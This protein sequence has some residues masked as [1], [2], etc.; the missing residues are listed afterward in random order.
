ME[1]GK[2]TPHWLTDAQAVE[3]LIYQIRHGLH[4]DWSYEIW[5]EV[6]SQIP[7]PTPDAQLDRKF[8]IVSELLASLSKDDTARSIIISDLG[9]LFDIDSPLEREGVIALIS[10]YE[11]D[12]E[13][14]PASAFAAALYDIMA[15][16]RD[17]EKVNIDARLEGIE[18][19]AKELYKLRHKLEAEILSQNKKGLEALLAS[20]DESTMS[21][22]TI[23][24][25]ILQAHEIL[26]KEISP[27]LQALL[28][29]VR[30]SLLVFSVATGDVGAVYQTLNATKILGDARTLPEKWF[31]EF[32]NR[33]RRTRQVMMAKAYLSEQLEDW[34]TLEVVSE[35]GI[36][37]Y[38]TYYDFYRFHGI[39][40]AKKGD[41]SRALQSLK[42]YCRYSKNELDYPAAKALLVEIEAASSP[43]RDLPADPEE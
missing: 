16:L 27:K 21:Q 33:C 38:P 29:K 15:R 37:D 40:M 41:L 31:E 39:T 11:K 28:K 36:T 7:H 8:T 35:Q 20:L 9:S 13:N 12:P 42:T 1:I 26:G 5:L 4:H 23:L 19:S 24:P 25:Y 17:G 30:D 34:K 14:A 6:C 3:L 32:S 18:H 22:S 2:A 43:S 10:P